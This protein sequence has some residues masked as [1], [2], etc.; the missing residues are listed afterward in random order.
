MFQPLLLCIWIQFDLD[1]ICA[2]SPLLLRCCVSVSE[3]L[4]WLLH[5][6]FFINCIIFHLW[7]LPADLMPF[8]LDS[9]SIRAYLKQ[10]RKKLYFSRIL[11]APLSWFT[12]CVPQLLC[13]FLHTMVKFFSFFSPLVLCIQSSQ[14]WESAWNW[15]GNISMRA[16]NIKMKRSSG[17]Y[18]NAINFNIVTIFHLDVERTCALS[19]LFIVQRLKCLTVWEMLHGFVFAC[20]KSGCTRSRFESSVCV[21]GFGNEWKRSDKMKHSRPAY[22]LDTYLLYTMPWKFA[23]ELVSLLVS[24][25]F[26]TFAARSPLLLLSIGKMPRTK[27]ENGIIFMTFFLFL[28]LSHHVVENL[29][30]TKTRR[31]WEW[32][33]TTWNK[34]HCSKYEMAI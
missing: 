14:R 4:L 33:S 24:F 30:K 7:N 11:R 20:G 31:E 23:C 16:V 10:T 12:L 18:K 6:F 8:S 29:G 34:F 15:N 2:I 27:H 28:S 21:W 25:L 26:L 9:L 17:A 3:F 5:V 19:N 22:R 32:L 13:A 1:A